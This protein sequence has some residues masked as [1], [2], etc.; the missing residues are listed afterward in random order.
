MLHAGEVGF[1]IAGI[2]DI[3]GAPVGD[4]ITHAKTPDVENIPGFQKLRL[5]SMQ[6]CSRLI[7]VILKNFVRHYKSF[8]LMMQH[9][10]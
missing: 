7:P 1:V 3:Q 6:G 5:K 9:Y 10:F 2:K 8:K 4:T